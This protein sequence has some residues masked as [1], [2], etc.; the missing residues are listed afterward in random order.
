MANF[1]IELTADRLRTLMYDAPHDTKVLI[2]DTDGSTREVSFISLESSRSFVP[3]IEPATLETGHETCG[4]KERNVNQLVIQ[5][6][7]IK[8][9]KKKYG[10]TRKD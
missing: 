6:E 5:L 1:P 8:H 4:Y 3:A 2:R 9:G 7:P 10:Q